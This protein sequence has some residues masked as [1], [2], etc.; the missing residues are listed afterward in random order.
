VSQLNPDIHIYGHS[1]V[2]RNIEVDDICYVNNAFAYPSEENISRKKLH[3][4][5]NT[6]NK[7]S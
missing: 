6:N 2:N 3:C 4:V 7:P 5:L 1:H